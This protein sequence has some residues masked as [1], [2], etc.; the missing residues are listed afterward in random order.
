MPI[1]LQAWPSDIE[2]S[3]DALRSRFSAPMF[4]VTDRE[5]PA[6][7][8]FHVITRAGSCFVL[9]GTVS[10]RDVNAEVAASGA[11][12]LRIPSGDYTFS[13]Q[14]D[15]HIVTVWPVPIFD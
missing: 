2:R 7:T 15:A 10:Y 5:Y 8:S 3:V 12:V 14:G 9:R 13:V 1:E 11:E 6:G 4:R